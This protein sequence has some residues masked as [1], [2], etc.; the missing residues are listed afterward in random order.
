MVINR[1]LSAMRKSRVLT[2][3]LRTTAACQE[4][5]VAFMYQATQLSDITSDCVMNVLC[6]LVNCMPIYVRALQAVDSNSAR[7]RLADN[8]IRAP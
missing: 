1:V 3:A 8:E 7:T 2:P 6:A 5:S 4:Q